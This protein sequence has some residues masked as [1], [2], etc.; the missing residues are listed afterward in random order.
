MRRNALASIAFGVVLTMVGAGL[1]LAQNS[2]IPAPSGPVNP[3]PATALPTYTESASPG[4]VNSAIPA[5]SPSETAVA[6]PT[7]TPVPIIVDPPQIGVSPGSPLTARVTGVFGTLAARIADPSVAEITAI[8]QG[9]RTVTIVGK[10]IGATTLTVSDDRGQTRDAPIRVAYPAGN[11]AD[12]TTIRITGS[13]ATADFV[14]TQAFNAARRVAQLRP[15]AQ[16]VASIDGVQ[17]AR[18][19]A[20][21]DVQVVDVPLQL[22][23]ADYFSVAGTTHVR[24]ENFAL[25]PIRPKQLLVSDY[26]ETLSENGVLFTADLDRRDAQRFLYYHANPAGAPARRIVLKCENATRDPAL[27]QFISGPAG[28][29]TNEMEVGHLSTQR[30]L[31]RVSQNEGAVI[32]IPPQTTMNLFDQL[33][34]PQ[35]VVSNLL[36]LREVEG[37]PL[38]LTL[39][40]QDATDPVDKPVTS[41]DLLEGGVKHARGVYPVPEFYFDYVYQVGGD[42]LEVSI[43]TLALPNLRQG[44][45]L[46]GDYGVLQSIS[47]TIVNPSGG[48][49]PLAIYENPRGGRAT[50]TFLIDRTL[51]QSHGV[52]AYSRFKLR[53]YKVPA[54]SIFRITLVTMPEGGSSYPVRLIV[55]PDDG[56]VSPGAPGSPVY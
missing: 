55:A 14:R 50:G 3:P 37:N 41:T 8:D 15:G 26:P 46:S 36:Q 35:N 9:D 42:D 33:L 56:S 52:P 6:V 49:T 54:H 23:G 47:V 21:D 17:G 31:V 25:P 27:V 51:V 19:L 48:T 28:P 44:E 43:G 18:N 45:A 40:A 24:V 10:A 39:V 13:P 1:G 16:V 22:S 38:K 5:P 20:A 34:P 11:V 7:A 32:T 2:P 29:G 4:P 53:E 30:F 12:A